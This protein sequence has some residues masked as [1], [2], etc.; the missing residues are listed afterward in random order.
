MASAEIAVSIRLVPDEETMQVMLLLLNMW[1]DSN[2]DKMIAMLPD[3]D[4]Y[5]YEI[6]NRK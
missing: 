4:R 5:I 3:H 2:P 6:I 1:Q